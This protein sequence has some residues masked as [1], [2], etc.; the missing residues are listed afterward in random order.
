[1]TYATELIMRT[2]LPFENI[3]TLWQGEE[4]VYD[5][6]PQEATA[7]F[8]HLHEKCFPN[9]NQAEKKFELLRQSL[10]LTKNSTLHHTQSFEDDRLTLSM[11]FENED[12]FR[13]KWEVIKKN[14]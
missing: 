4:T 11:V 8:D 10:Q 13:E 5:N 14:L 12:I 1:M 7:L 2:E 3:I 9:I 6:R